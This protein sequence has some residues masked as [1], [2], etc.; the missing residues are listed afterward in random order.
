LLNAAAPVELPRGSETPRIWSYPPS[1]ASSGDEIA[2]FCAENGLTLLP[3]QR[4]V[5][6]TA[7]GER[8]DGQWSASEVGLVVSRQNGKGSV[9]EARE[10]GGMFLL[11]ERIIHTAQQFRT[12]TDGF[13]RILSLIEGSPDLDSRVKRK[14]NSPIEKSIE[15]KNGAKI[16]F[17]AR[18]PNAGRGLSKTDVLVFD[19][20]YDLNEAERSALVPTMTASQNPQVWYTSSAG[21]PH[22]VILSE[23][24]QRGIDGWPT[25]A[26]MEWSVPQPERGD[27]LPD[28]NDLANIAMANPSLGTKFLGQDYLAMEAGSM[29]LPARARERL[30]VFDEVIGH[31]PPILPPGSWAATLD[32]GSQISGHVDFGLEVAQDRSWSCIAAAG[33]RT[34]GLLHVQVAEN[35]QGTG[36][37][38]GKLRDLGADEVALSPNSPAG[39]L[40]DDLE[41]AGIK[42]VKYPTA[43]YAAACGKFHDLVRDGQLRHLDQG[44]L[45][46]AI[47]GASKRTS[48]DAYVYDR[49]GDIDI[50]PLS[51]V[52]LAAHLASLE[53]VS[54][55]EERGVRFL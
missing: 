11:G 36:W 50:S 20:A 28:P 27:P 31:E 21:L 47:D 10:L 19:E 46:M 40:V 53:R 1:V 41:L 23:V 7:M 14:L 3:W 15:L 38:V 39:S 35:H 8:A 49:R 13:A 18:G 54:V 5:L 52:V 42:V 30:G 17:I 26:Y 22:S 55:Y 16:M 9:L 4:L 29:S 32:E 2:D 45:S 34:D 6:R 24:R 48:G 37:I 43:D 33:K 51:A 25:L 44:E 12:A